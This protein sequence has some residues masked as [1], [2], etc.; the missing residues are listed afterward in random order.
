MNRI[1]WWQALFLCPLI[2]SGCETGAAEPGLFPS[3]TTD[4]ALAAKTLVFNLP[5]A[6]SPTLTP[7]LRTPA[8]PTNTET[9]SP[10]LSPSLPITRLPSDTYDPAS[11]PCLN[12]LYPLA[13]GRRWTYS[14][15]RGESDD[16]VVVTVIEAEGNDAIVD[17]MDKTEGTHSSFIVNCSEGAL[18]DFSITEIGFLFFSTG[19]SLKVSSTSGL[20]APPRS[21]FEEKNWRY[22]WSTGLTASGEMVLQD[23]PL[24]ETIMKFEDSP[25]EIDWE[26]TGETETLQTPAGLFPEARLFAARANFNMTVIISGGARTQSFPAVL[27][28]GAFLWYQPNVGMLK[29][30][31]TSGVVIVGGYKYP[32]GLLSQMELID[33]DFPP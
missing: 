21:Q 1:W 17:F 10:T 20:L 30:I 27:E 22:G 28:L 16:A 23:L 7:S 6:F 24:G 3:A 4:P 15:K 18:T 8:S 29:Q 12:I 19:A 5:P 26:S 9:P 33:Y 2:L 14:L 11:P 32:I 25:V 31:F 13:T